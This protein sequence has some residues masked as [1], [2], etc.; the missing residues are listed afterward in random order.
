MASFL[1]RLLVEKTLLTKH[2]YRSWIETLR[3][4][5]AYSL[6]VCVLGPALEDQTWASSE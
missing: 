1:F 3:V 2:L 4:A 6:H 5:V